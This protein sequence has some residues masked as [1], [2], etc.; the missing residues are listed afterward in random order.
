MLALARKAL[1]SES[2]LLNKTILE[3][4]QR[5]RLKSRRPFAIHAQE[6]LSTTPADTSRASWVKA[7]WREQWRAAEPSRLHRY[8]EDPTDV[9]DVPDVPTF[10]ESS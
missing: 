8:I 5:N 1:T 7:R 9:P 4:P 10:P 2:H 3:R 6:L